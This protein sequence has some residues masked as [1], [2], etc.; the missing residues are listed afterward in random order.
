LISLFVLRLGIL[1]LGVRKKGNLQKKK[2]GLCHR[3]ALGIS[4]NFEELATTP[5]NEV[6]TLRSLRRSAK[7]NY[8]GIVQ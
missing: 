7:L 8:L 5:R 2:I 3:H 6:T 1:G 4:V